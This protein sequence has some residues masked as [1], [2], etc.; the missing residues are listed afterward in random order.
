MSFR[1]HHVIA[2]AALVLAGAAAG[3]SDA[4][5]PADV[6]S[7]ST[8]DVPGSASTAQV[9]ASTV[10]VPGSDTPGADVPAALDFRAPLVG[11]GEFDGTEFAGRPVVFWFWAPT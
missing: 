5:S 6:G 4:R 3:C 8:I 10:E 2:I 11:G 1:R 9:P 7:A